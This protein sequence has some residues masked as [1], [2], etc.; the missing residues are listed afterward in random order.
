M[1]TAIFL[2]LLYIGD[3]IL[4]SFTGNFDIGYSD[5]GNFIVFIFIVLFVMDVVELIRRIKKW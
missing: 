1:R 4:K 3:C 5:G 2:G